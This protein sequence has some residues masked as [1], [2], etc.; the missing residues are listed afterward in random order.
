MKFKNL[1]VLFALIIAIVAC[2][3]D[4]DSNTANFDAAAQ[5]II[6]DETL[7]EYLQTH[8]YIPAQENE[9]FGNIDTIENGEVSLYSQI[10]TQNI[11][12]DEID[13]KLYYLTLNEGVNDNPTRYDSVFV[14]YRG[15]TL[16]SVKFD[17][18]VNF[19]QLNANGRPA[20]WLDLLNVINGWKYGFPNFKSGTNVSVN[21]EPITFEDTGKGILF[22]PSGLAYGNIGT[23]FGS[24]I[25]EPLIFHIEL[26]QVIRSDHDNDGVLTRFEDLNGDGVFDADNDDTDQDGFPDYFDN[27]DDGDGILTIDEDTDE[28]GDPR[29]DDT[30]GDGI[31][32]YL[33]ADS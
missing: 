31:P 22:I 29:N 3:N 28:D 12:E 7:I 1:I 19:N 25:N 21:G 24:L 6:D 30:D 18:L 23:Q 9:N 17:E 16:D 32:N 13:Y 8:Y 14:K 11:T 20:A 10:N 26:G 5:A 2:N 33:D 15:F 27:D 4:D